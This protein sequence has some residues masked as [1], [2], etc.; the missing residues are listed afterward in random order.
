MIESTGNSY[1]KLGRWSGTYLSLYKRYQT[2]YPAPEITLYECTDSVLAESQLLILF[3]SYRINGELFDKHVVG[4]FNDEI[5]HL[6]GINMSSCTHHDMLKR[7]E[8]RLAREEKERI[9]EELKEAERTLK[10]ESEEIKRITKKRVKVLKIYE[11]ARLK[12][13]PMIQEKK[14]R[15]C[16]FLL[17]KTVYKK[18]NRVLISDIKDSLSTYLGT[19]IRKIDN[20]TFSHV[21]PEYIIEKIKIC[22]HCTKKATKGC[23]ESYCYEDRLCRATVLNI[24]LLS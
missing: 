10:K 21:N 11:Q 6:H 18:G 4:F 9:A 13:A 12:N 24:E 17:E 1:V 23:C 2:Y 7:I 3:K 8:K 19:P 5:H 20:G 22:K 15:L 16:D 14:D